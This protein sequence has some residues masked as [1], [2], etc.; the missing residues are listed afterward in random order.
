MEYQRNERTKLAQWKMRALAGNADNYDVSTERRKAISIRVSDHGRMLKWGSSDD[1]R[2]QT[3]QPQGL[4]DG[5]C[6]W[7]DTASHSNQLRV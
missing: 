6:S 7:E 4:S 1:Q 2:D 5:G 3:Y